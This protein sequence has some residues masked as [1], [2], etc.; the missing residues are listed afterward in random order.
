MFPHSQTPVPLK[1]HPMHC[2][3]ACSNSIS[4]QEFFEILSLKGLFGNH[5]IFLAFHFKYFFNIF[6]IFKEKL[7]SQTI[8]FCTLFPWNWVF[9][10]LSENTGPWGFEDL[11][12]WV[13]LYSVPL[14]P[15]VFVWKYWSEAQ[16]IPIV[17]LAHC[18]L[19]P[20]WGIPKTKQTHHEQKKK[21]N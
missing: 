14:S 3:E 2:N 19:W 20:T 21:K 1:L 4:L 6:T 18:R 5:F 17:H 13:L 9:L 8:A 10:F 7:Q 11:S 15:S 16:C 12:P